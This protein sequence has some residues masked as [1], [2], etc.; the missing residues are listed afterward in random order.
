MLQERSLRVNEE[1]TRGHQRGQGLCF[2]CGATVGNEHMPSCVCRQRTVIVRVTIDL[3]VSVPES[4][5]VHSIEFHRNDSSRCAG[6]T[7]NEIEEARK[8]MENVGCVCFCTEHEYVREATEDDERDYAW[9]TLDEAGTQ[10][11]PAGS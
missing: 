9:N 10:I 7:W 2:Y 5:D 11:A 6:G 8:R 4:W 1:D 3:L